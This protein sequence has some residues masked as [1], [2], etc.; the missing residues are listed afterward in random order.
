MPPTSWCTC[1]R[2]GSLAHITQ[3]IRDVYFENINFARES[4]PTSF[5]PAQTSE[6]HRTRQCRERQKSCFGHG[7]YIEDASDS[8]D[9]FPGKR[10]SRNS[11]TCAL[12]SGGGQLPGKHFRPSVD[13]A[14]DAGLP[15]FR[16]HFLCHPLGVALHSVGGHDH[17]S[18]KPRLQGSR[19][20]RE[21]ISR[22]SPSRLPA[23][24]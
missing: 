5:Q 18:N 21:D 20:R 8:V 2:A 17:K 1:F 22:G 9:N 15:F 19:C 16:D 14:E 3:W 23:I 10:Y 12:R 6:Q 11:D 7:V 24:R 4:L 13:K